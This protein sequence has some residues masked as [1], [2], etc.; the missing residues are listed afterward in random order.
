MPGRR[1]KQK[2]SIN[3][4]GEPTLSTVA[5]TVTS[6][7]CLS[8]DQSKATGEEE[9]VLFT[10]RVA[11]SAVRSRRRT[12]GGAGAIAAVEASGWPRTTS[13]PWTRQVDAAAQTVAWA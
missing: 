5:S 11:V 6:S 4:F 9:G 7:V 2:R 13:P 1:P 8:Q 3:A 12:S 10:M